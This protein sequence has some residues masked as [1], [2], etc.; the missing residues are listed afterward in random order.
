MKQ[1]KIVYAAI[2]IICFAGLLCY[3]GYY[4]YQA[5]EDP[6]QTAYAV[7]FE[8]FDSY[9]AAGIIVRDE[10]VLYSN[11]SN[12][13]ITRSEGEKVGSNQA[14]ALAFNDGSA[15]ERRAEI[16]DLELRISQ[17][18][19]TIGTTVEVLDG[20]KLD[21]AIVNA[22]IGMNTSVQSRSISAID[23]EALT[24][25]NLIFNRE[26]TY[27]EISEIENEI[28]ELQNRLNSLNSI[29]KT[30]TNEIRTVASGI[31]SAYVDGYERVLNAAALESMTVTDLNAISPLLD[32]MDN[33]I[34]KVITSARW[35]FVMAIPEDRAKELDGS[36]KVRFS[37]DFNTDITMSLERVGVATG[38]SCLVVLSSDEHLSDMTLLRKQTVDIIYNS[39]SGIRIMKKAIRFD[40]DGN[41]GVYCLEGLNAVFKKVDIIYEIGDFY[42]VK[43]DKSSIYKLW[44]GNEVIIAG[45]DLFD[46]KVVGK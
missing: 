32:D 28:A 39:Y 42:I 20:A 7:E 9:T 38:G 45:K 5:L 35:Y 2:S 23:R 33:S 19:S 14:V 16:E 15:R 21:D 31:Y 44:A 30:E 1:G 37:Q 22:I 3:L 27:S 43:N 8:A 24:L 10:Q 29:S 26:Y 4:I 11:Q 25:K 36:V 12:L 6:L 17:L 40:E 41:A 13:V 34:G 46:G 18:S